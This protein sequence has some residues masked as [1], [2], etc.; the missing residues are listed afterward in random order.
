MAPALWIRPRW[1]SHGLHDRLCPRTGLSWFNCWHCRMLGLGRRQ[2]QLSK[3]CAKAREPWLPG[4]RLAS[5]VD[6]YSRLSKPQ[7]P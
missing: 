5:L 7:Q 6:H 2:M 1:M 3:R 4:N